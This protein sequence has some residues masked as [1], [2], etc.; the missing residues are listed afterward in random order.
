MPTQSFFPNV[1]FKGG[2]IHEIGPVGVDNAQV[3]TNSALGL[4]Q[5]R[6]SDYCCFIN[7]PMSDWHRSIPEYFL[8]QHT[9]GV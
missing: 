5:P 4:R 6:I 3:R 7:Y 2:D 9:Y 8:L 1:D